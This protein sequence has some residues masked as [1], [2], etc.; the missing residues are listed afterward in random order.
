M[1]ASRVNNMKEEGSHLMEGVND[2]VDSIVQAPQNWKDQRRKQKYKENRKKYNEQA[3]SLRQK[4]NLEKKKK[5]KN[6]WFQ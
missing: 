1:L 6:S 2:K 3:D 4:Y 5:K